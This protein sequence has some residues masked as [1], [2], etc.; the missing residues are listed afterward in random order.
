MVV[1]VPLD[2][3]VLALTLGVATVTG[4]IAGAAPA[5]IAARGQLSSALSRAGA[6]T[7]S[8]APRLRSGL[9]V[10][11]L[12]LSLTLLIGALLLVSTVRNLRAVDLGFDPDKITAFNISLSSQGYSNTTALT[13][14]RDIHTIAESGGEFEA[15]TLASATPFGGTFIIRV[16]PPEAEAG[17]ELEV[18]GVGVSANYFSTLAMTFLRGRGFTDTEAFSPP[19]A[20]PTPIIVSETMAHRLF[21]SIDVL[22]RTV[23]I[24]RT[25]N[26]PER[27]LPIIG[28]VRDARDGLTGE[29][30]PFMF[31]PFGSFDFGATRGAIMV[32]SSKPVA[33][34]TTAIR[35]L[36]GRLDRNLP[37]PFGVSLTT[38][39][40]RD[41]RTERLFA[42]TLSVLGV[43]GFVLAALGVY[44]LV[45]QTTAERSRE[46]G[47]RMAIGAGRAQIAKLVLEFGVR[48]AGI[49]TLVGVG[50]AWFGSK[51]VA[52]LLFGITPL[53]PAV[54][55]TAALTLA[56]VVAAACAIP[57]LRAMRVQPVDVLR[58]D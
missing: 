36:V 21:G 56:C 57:A 6:R 45:A 24:A 41:M 26:N 38:Q 37:V 17:G 39:I 31:M 7:I 53:S 15:V 51:T 11:Q 43:I 50:L 33:Q 9:A 55:L 34:I 48:I 35:S 18:V 44:G 10:A 1:E 58:A 13:L 23:R 5:W 14:W 8:R 25:L 27:D 12:A 46:F 22:G 19:S 29:T 40:E 3:R 4:L 52:G 20:M 2:A 49:G 42:W 16:L 30:D 47:I 28:V 54:Y 32:K